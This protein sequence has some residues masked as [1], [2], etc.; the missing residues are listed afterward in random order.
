H[1]LVQAPPQQCADLKIPSP[2]E[3]KASSEVILSSRTIILLYPHHTCYWHIMKDKN[4][5]DS[6]VRCC[7]YA[8]SIVKMRM[9]QELLSTL[10]GHSRLIKS[11]WTVECSIWQ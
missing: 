10:P 9:S 3:L 5:A 6:I 11:C 1:A 2:R 7:I 8:I 4:N